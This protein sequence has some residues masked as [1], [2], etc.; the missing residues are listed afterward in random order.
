[1]AALKKI[2]V[3]NLRSLRSIPPLRIAPITVLLGKNSVGKSTFARV[4]PLFRQSA[5]RKKQSPV[6]WFGN[7]VDFGSL[8][9]TVS[10]GEK[11]ISFCFHIQMEL[12]RRRGGG[13]IQSAISQ[14][15]IPVEVTITLG[16]DETQQ[17]G[18]AKKVTVS[19]LGSVVSVDLSPSDLFIPFVTF[20]GIAVKQVSDDQRMVS[21]QGDIFPLMYFLKRNTDSAGQTTFQYIPNPWDDQAT[22][23]IKFAVHQNTSTATCRR[24]AQQISLGTKDQIEQAIGGIVGPSGWTSLK[25]SVVRRRK[26]AADLHQALI[27]ANLGEVFEQVDV[28]LSSYFKG[29]RYLKPL[30]ATAERYYRRLDLSVSEIDP[31]GSN[32]AIFLDSL[33]LGQLSLFRDWTKKYL[34]IDAYPKRDGDQVVVMAQGRN[35]AEA[36]NIA[37]MGFGISQVLPIAAQLWVTTQN[38]KGPQST[39][40]V[41]LEQPEL[42]LHPDSQARLAD[43]FAGAIRSNTGQARL[44]GPSI[45]IETHSQH[46]VNRLGQLIEK[47]V[48]DAS[49]VSILLFESSEAT[50][51]AT[52]V[53]VAEFN[54]Q[55]ILKNWPYGFFEPES[56]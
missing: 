12:P 34:D 42:H 30:R 39:S 15:K 27:L 25:Q 38:A 29:V 11:E 6:L 10:V 18:V 21:F 23:K 13:L 3:T 8:A 43:V 28:T 20:N 7:L 50:R 40:I 49:E 5:E 51:S 36:F 19:L 14:P 41:V 46:V 22:Q 52:E 26:L 4:F 9:R 17:S 48:L 53:K 45:L 1:V 24:I 55:G 31:D 35:D 56:E 33:S 47:G 32:L 54:D 44:D 37:D 16:E 2:G